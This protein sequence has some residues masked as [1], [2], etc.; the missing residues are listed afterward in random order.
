MHHK[1][2]IKIWNG[3]GLM[4]HFFLFYL[5]WNHITAVHTI[6][7]SAVPLKSNLS[8]HGLCHFI[9]IAFSRNNTTIF[10]ISILFQYPQSLTQMLLLKLYTSC[11]KKCLLLDRPKANDCF[12]RAT[13]SAAAVTAW[14][15]RPLNRWDK[16][17]LRLQLNALHEVEHDILHWKFIIFCSVFLWNATFLFFSFP[18]FVLY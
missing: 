1:S 14:V 8:F 6:R 18:I 15:V 7:F 10:L 2:T 4:C 11:T 12:L 9:V 13:I 17:L 5:I 3:N 16:I